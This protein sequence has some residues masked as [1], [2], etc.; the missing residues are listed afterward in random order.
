MTELR[1]SSPLNLC[2]KAL[3]R[4]RQLKEYCYVFVVYLIESEDRIVRSRSI[5]HSVTH[6]IA[7]NID[8]I[9]FTTVFKRH[10]ILSN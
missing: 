6:C 1:F 3:V 5:L 7:H 8:F 9:Q 10:K 2:V 4:K